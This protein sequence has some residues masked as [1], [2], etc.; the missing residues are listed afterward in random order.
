MRE[1]LQSEAGPTRMI[2]DGQRQMRL[3]L[4]IRLDQEIAAPHPIAR[5]PSWD[6][7]FQFPSSMENLILMSSNPVRNIGLAHRHLSAYSPPPI[8]VMRNRSAACLR[9]KRLEAN[10]FLQHPCGFR[11][12][13]DPVGC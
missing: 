5:D 9:H 1:P 2:E 8:E 4:P 7:V 6:S 12:G 13:E 10:D 11:L 3:A